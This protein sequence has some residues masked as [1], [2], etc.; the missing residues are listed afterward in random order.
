MTCMKV[1]LLLIVSKGKRRRHRH[2]R[3][4]TFHPQPLL[5]DDQ[6]GE[7]QRGK[8][9]PGTRVPFAQ[10]TIG[11]YAQVLIWKKEAEPAVNII[12]TSHKTII[13]TKFPAA[14]IDKAITAA[15][16]VIGVVAL[17]DKQWQAIE[18]FIQGNDVFVCLPTGFGKSQCYA[19]LLLVYENLKKCGGSIVICISLLTSLMEQTSKFSL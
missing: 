6:E 10:P 8:E 18:C 3:R 14:A 5:T 9:G 12:I 4:Y 1:W 13:M 19:L 15:C 17:K 7:G 16:V 2:P 11:M